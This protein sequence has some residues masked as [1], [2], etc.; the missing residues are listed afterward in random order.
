MPYNNGFWGY[1]MELAELNRVII[2]HNAQI[3]RRVSGGVTVA[4]TNFAAAMSSARRRARPGSSLSLGEASDALAS[5]HSALAKLARLATGRERRRLKTLMDIVL[6][7]LRAV[8]QKILDNE[9]IR[10][11]GITEKLKAAKDD[12]DS[13][14]QK[15]KRQLAN[16]QNATA[17]LNA[18]GKLVSAIS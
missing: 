5:T 18:F 10:Y 1:Q 7:D 9:G 11:R 15:A 4:P 14:H 8:T 3:R 16:I 13:A 6:E 12:L 17:I 2:N